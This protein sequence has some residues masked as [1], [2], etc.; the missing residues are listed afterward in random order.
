MIARSIDAALESRVFDAVLVSTD[1]DEI[2]AVAESCG[3]EV[4][5][6]RPA[7]LSGDHAPT[8]PV[9][10]HAIRWWE[11]NRSQVDNACC[12]YATA[13]FLQPGFLREGLETLRQHDDAEFAFSV[14]SYAFPIFRALNIPD[15][16]RVQMF[17]PENEMKRSQDLPE[18]WHD[19]GQFYWG[20]KDAFLSHHGVFGAVSYPVVLPRHLVQDIDTP[21]DWER[22]ERMFAAKD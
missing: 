21:E 7:E 15:H 10:A 5:F 13:P 19:A 9:V 14:T 11:Q 20:R 18:A 2:A 4:P 8:L 6:R 3:A 17:W 1:S 22:A 12:I 16:G